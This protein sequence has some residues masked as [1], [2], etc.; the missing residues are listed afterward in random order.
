MVWEECQAVA[1]RFEGNFGFAPHCHFTNASG[2]KTGEGRSIK[3]VG[4]SDFVCVLSADIWKVS[5]TFCTRLTN[6]VLWLN[7][8]VKM[9]NM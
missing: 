3:K 6:A 4:G 7:I 2:G 9:T 1:A 8:V 5:R